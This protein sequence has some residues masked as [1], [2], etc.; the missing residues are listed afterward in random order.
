MSKLARIF[1]YLRA[2]RGQVFILMVLVMMTAI[3]TLLL[4]DFMSRIIGEG[5]TAEYRLLDD[6]ELGYTLTDRDTCLALEATECIVVQQS[7]LS[8]IIKYGLMMVGVTLISSIATVGIS[9]LSASVSTSL[10]RDIRKDIFERVSHFSLKEADQFGTSTLI[11]RSTNDVVQVQMFT[12]MAFRMFAVIPIIFIGGIIMSLQKSARLTAILLFGVPALVLFIAFVF[13]KVLPLFK[14]MQKKIDQLTLVTREGINGVRV[15]RAFGQGEKEVKR[16][17]DANLDLTN[18]SLKA[19]TI[20]SSLNPFV[21]LLFSFVVMGVIFLAYRGVTDSIP[22][23]YQ[24]LA[25]TSAVIQYVNQIMFALIMLTFAFI[26]Y[27]RA[28]VSI[29]RIGEVLD[30]KTSILDAPTD[31][32]DT[33]EFQGNIRFEDVCFRYQDA[34][35]NVLDHISF[36]AN[37]GETVA[38]IGSTGSGKSTIINLIPRFFDVSCGK[39]T[40]DGIDIR[41]IK[42]HKLRSLLGFVPQTATLFTGSIRENITYGKQDVSDEEMKHAAKIAQATE[43]IESLE[44]QYDSFVDQGGVNFSG[45]QKQRMSIARAI[46]RKPNVYIFDDTF[47]ALDFKTDAL[48]RKALKEETKHATVI[49][50]AQRIGTIMDADRIIVLQDGQIVASGKHKELLKSSTVYQEIALSQLS[51]EELQ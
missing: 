3:G 51:E 49:I 37:V 29:K 23:S 9:Y 33:V 34:E 22:S 4:P 11:T 8:V 1:K 6:S 50:V 48:L 17:E 35:K 43:F 19:G 44:K 38:I 14:A 41:D 45:G 42:F 47:S 10:G 12:M 31:A 25:N 7:D 18:N 46:V 36:E 5:I 13:W 2:Y 28:E 16:F 32:Y 30:T 15:I 27:P 24:E 39:I 26:G 40:I 20:M 21:N